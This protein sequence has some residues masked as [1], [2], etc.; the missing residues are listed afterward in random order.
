M[1][2]PILTLTDGA[3]T[4]TLLEFVSTYFPFVDEPLK[5]KYRG[6][7]YKVATT[8]LRKFE[9]EDFFIS[10]N[11]LKCKTNCCRHMYIPIGFEGYWPEEKLKLIRSFKIRRYHIEL[12]DRN[13]IYYIAFV[14][15][16]CKFQEGKACNI[17]DSN[18]DLQRRP[19][20]C[21]FYPMTWYF[22]DDTLT[23]TKHCYPFI[24]KAESSL[25]TQE[26]FNLDLNTFK[27][28]C[29]EIEALGLAVNYRP[30]EAL[31]EQAYFSI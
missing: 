16:H 28:L 8:Q 25:Y 21:Y 31:E 4:N 23:F 29:K 17:W 3:G 7:T 14:G 24:C 9:F 15:N 1:S 11:C 20:G 5:L 26:N 2:E 13:L 10:F 12:N 27:K 18:S 6:R 19:M 30:V 22:Y